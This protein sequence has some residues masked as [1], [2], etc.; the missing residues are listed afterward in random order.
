[1]LYSSHRTPTDKSELT[2]L[3][4][5]YSSVGEAGN[6]D[7]GIPPSPDWFT[8]ESE[9]MS[10]TDRETKVALPSSSILSY[11]PWSS[12]PERLRKSS[13]SSIGIPHRLSSSDYK[14]VSH[15]AERSPRTHSESLL[16]DDAVFTSPMGQYHNKRL[17]M[18]TNLSEHYTPSPTW[19]PVQQSEAAISRSQSIPKQKRF[20]F[21]WP[22]EE[23][24]DNVTVWSPLLLKL[25]A[26]E[27]GKNETSSSVTGSLD[28]RIRSLSC[29]G[30]AS[31]KV[32]FDDKGVVQSR[33]SV[34]ILPG[35]KNTW[36]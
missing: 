8:D 20:Y 18:I 2:R 1:Q 13:G 19:S 3:L 36:V 21:A 7:P 28:G 14:N 34:D 16:L 23:E 29:G 24:E 17:W 6:M 9:N 31:S 32:D 4:R 33:Y 10:F 26:V 11:S 27:M 30:I 35:V 5:K 12:T 25:A 15:L 22:E